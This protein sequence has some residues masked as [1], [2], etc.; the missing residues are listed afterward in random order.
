MIVIWVVPGVAEL[1]AVS[2]ST[3]APVVGLVPHDAV[4]PLGSVLVTARV[5]LPVNPPASVTEI[6]AEPVAP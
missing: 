3:L 2:V 1:V 5:T 6:V 4:T